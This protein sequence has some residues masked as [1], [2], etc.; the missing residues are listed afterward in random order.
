MQEMI[1]PADQLCMIMERI[2]DVD[3]TSLTGG[4]A[5]MMDD[6]GVMWVTPTSIDKKSLTRDDIVKILPDGTIE[7]KHKPTSEYYIHRSILLKR[8][9]IKAV[10]HAHAPAT[11]TISVLNQ[12]PETRICGK[13]YEVAG[14]P[15]LTPYA[16]PGSMGLVDRVM[17]AFENGY[18]SAMLE[19]HS[20]F[21]GS[22]IGLLEA[23][24][25][26]EALDIASRIQIN[27]YTIGEPKKIE[28]SQ[29]E[30]RLESPEKLFAEKEI[31]HTCRELDARR[32]LADIV[33][34]G[35]TKKLFA[36]AIGVMSVRTGGN[37]FVITPMGGDNGYMTVSDLVF[38]EGDC[39]EKGKIPHETA[40]LHKMIY[41]RHPEVNSVILASPV[42]TMGFAVTGTVYDTTLYPESYGVLQHCNFYTYEQFFSE[43]EKIAEGLDLEHPM[44][45]IDNCGVVLAGPTPI[46]AFDKLEVCESSAQSMHESRRMGFEPPLMTQQQ[47]DEMNE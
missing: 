42:Y 7:G 34:R 21:V 23:F 36:S 4:N 16:L 10:I 31:S 18:D 14:L 35:Y 29:L 22:K 39:R 30:N 19:K 32:K 33:Q 40:L 13:T 17:G 41:D 28:D 8:P 37:S 43:Q 1:H 9:D 26:F 11:V 47:I 12:V 46:L 15:G 27:S 38:V 44:A 24:Q 6:E 5:S 45:M 20:A 3:M 25:K 2:Y